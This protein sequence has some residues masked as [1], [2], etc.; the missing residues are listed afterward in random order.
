MAIERRTVVAAAPRAD[1]RIVAQSGALGETFE[2]ELDAPGKK[3]RGVWGDYVEGT[4]RALVARG[5]AVGGAKLYIESDVPPG[6]GLALAALAG[7]S[8]LD[9][10]TLA[11]AGQAAEHEYVGT[12]CGIMDQYIAALGVE[13]HALLVDCRSLEAK[14]IPFVLGGERLVVCDTG[15]K[16]EL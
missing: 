1:R 3:R 5:V 14:K 16:H 7:A 15:V 8:G 12:M 10:V 11:Q 6:G 9:R 2:L 13:R 4:A